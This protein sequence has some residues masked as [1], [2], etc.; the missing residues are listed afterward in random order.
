MLTRRSG[1]KLVPVAY[2]RDRVPTLFDSLPRRVVG[3]S[4]SDHYQ[5][6]ALTAQ[7]ATL[8]QDALGSAYRLDRE[9]EAGGMSR[10]F[11][12]TDVKLN[13]QVVVKVLPPDLVSTASIARFK[14]EI[15]LTVRLQHPHILPIITSG[16]YDDV[17]YYITPFIPGES[18][19]ERIA[20]DGKLPLD[21]IVKILRDVGGALAFAHQRGVAHRDIKPGNI[22][23]A[24]GHAILADFGIARAVSTTATPLTD[25]GLAPGTPAYMAPELPTDERA[26]VYALGVVAYE[27]LCGALPRAHV[28]AAAIA[29]ARR[30]IAGD[31]MVRRRSLTRLVVKATGPAAARPA[32]ARSFV[33][34]IDG[35]PAS[36]WQTRQARLAVFA[37][38]MIA[39]IASIERPWRPSHA[40]NEAGYVVLSIG[41]HRPGEEENLKRVREAL[42]E[43]TG[44]VLTASGS[45]QTTTSLAR[46]VGEAIQNTRATGVRNLIVLDLVAG[47]DQAAVK[48]SL[49]DVASSAVTKVRQE[50]LTED[51]LLSVM[52]AR[53]LVNSILRDGHE[54][55]WRSAQDISQHSLSAWRQYDLGRANLGR[56]QLVAAE[57]AFRAAVTLEPDLALANLW[58]GQTLTWNESPQSGELRRRSAIAALTSRQRLSPQDSLLAAGVRALADSDFATGCGIYQQILR[59]DSTSFETWLGLGEC[60]RRDR[61]VVRRV[62]SATGWVFRGSHAAAARAYQRAGDLAPAG[63]D[64]LFRG[65]LVGRLARVLYARNEKRRLGYA[66]EGDT[67]LFVAAARLHHDTLSFDPR[68]L[69]QPRDTRTIR[70][71]EEENAAVTRS[72]NVLR[73][74]AEQWVLK[75]PRSADAYDSLASFTEVTNGA[76]TVGGRPISALEAVRKARTLSRD[77]AQRLELAIA[78]TRLLLKSAMF[79]EAEHLADSILRATDTRVVRSDGVAGLAALLGRRNLAAELTRS[80]AG[81][82]RPNTPAGVFLTPSGQLAE[83][84]LSLLSYAALQGPVDSIEAISKRLDRTIPSYVAEERQIAV[85]RGALIVPALT[86]GFPVTARLLGEFESYPDSYLKAQLAALSGAPEI[87]RQLLRATRA[88]RLG[89]LPGTVAAD[90]TIRQVELSLAVGD[91]SDATAELDAVLLALPTLGTHLLT[92]PEQVASLV[93][94]MRLRAELARESGDGATARNWS[95][96]VAQLWRDPDADLTPI[97]GRMKRLSL[98]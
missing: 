34:A 87:A 36:I 54:I 71:V 5:L 35:I 98:H 9:L 73:Q 48:A 25:S 31:S 66:A 32:S 39:A 90:E 6:F 4:T 19:R 63:T 27:M 7:L 62:S 83:L 79:A 45:P 15:E 18:L 29:A 14:R 26:D 40:L 44:T 8:L 84:S 78:E 12:A 21:D 93:R 33:E 46:T 77:S 72:R 23:L 47:G 51:S 24:D 86:L 1:G 97:L 42:S 88:R 95:R 22:L 37:S 85:M 60:N 41:G 76:A 67:V 28:D 43:W 82:F 75:A 81:S 69:G 13:R 80:S 64:S 16:A 68:P 49:V 50:R 58:L 55:P 10:L 91:T 59:R 17:L 52:D 61:L 74:A 89:A 53:R 3:A 11:L 96:A 56:W 70:E 20:R 30:G 94:G 57:S 65:W 2:P 38:I 92:Q